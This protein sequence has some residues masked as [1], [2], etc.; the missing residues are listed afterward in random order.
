M[1]DSGS[2]VNVVPKVSKTCAS[3]V[4]GSAVSRSDT[5]TQGYCTRF[6]YNKNVKPHVIEALLAKKFVKYDS[7]ATEMPRV[8]SRVV[9]PSR[10]IVSELSAQVQSPEGKVF[11]SKCEG[12]TGK[13]TPVEVTHDLAAKVISSPGVSMDTITSNMTTEKVSTCC[14]HIAKVISLPGG[15]ADAGAKVSNRPNDQGSVNADKANCTQDVPNNPNVIYD[16]K[17]QGVLDKFMNSILHVNQFSG[18]IPDVDIDI[19]HKWREQSE[20]NFGF[21][22]LGDQKFPNNFTVNESQ[23]LT[24]LEMHD[25]VRAANK[26]NYMEARLPVKSQLKV[27]A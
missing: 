26:P 25:I 22:P 8:A 7:K 9:W 4:A 12:A 3:S 14:D 6:V 23:G 16:V 27:D 2:S 10:T 18:I 5:E 20:F 19:Y 1:K 13:L 17:N 11:D 15:D 21:V 24:P